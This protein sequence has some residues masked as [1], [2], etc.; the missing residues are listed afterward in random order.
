M[1]AKTIKKL[2]EKISKKGY[3]EKRLEKL[4]ERRRIRN[5]NSNIYNFSNCISALCIRIDDNY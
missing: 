1:K 4:V 3:Y 2:R 5:E